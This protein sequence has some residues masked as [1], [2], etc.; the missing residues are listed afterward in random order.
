MICLIGFMGS[1]KTTVGEALAYKLGFK[2]VDLD[3][4]IEEQEKMTIAKI[5]EEKG[6]AHF[7]RLETKYLQV[8]ADEEQLVLSTGGGIIV[9]PENRVLLQ[10]HQTFYLNW[11]FDTLYQRIAGDVTRPLATSYEALCTR[12]EMRQPFYKEASDMTIDCEGKTIEAVVDEIFLLGNCFL[13]E[14]SKKITN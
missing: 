12:Y 11:E 13:Y 6:E 9:T 14:K 7:R 2:W 3:F 1:G 4:Y 10:Q 5:F 8:F